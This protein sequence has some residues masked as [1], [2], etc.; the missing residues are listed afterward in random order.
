MQE[1]D[2][3]R[4]RAVVPITLGGFAYGVGDELL[5]SQA[6]AKQYKVR[7]DLGHPQAVPVEEGAVAPIAGP[8]PRAAKVV[9][10]AGGGK[11]K[12]AAK[13]GQYNTRRLLAED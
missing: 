7:A 2:R 9:K 8:A 6:R 13:K 10:P 1:G 12:A 5:V 4:M 11:K 3:I